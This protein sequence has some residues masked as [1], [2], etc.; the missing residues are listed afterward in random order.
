MQRFQGE[1]MFAGGAFDFD[2]KSNGA[3]TKS[4]GN[5]PD[6]GVDTA[7]SHPIDFSVHRIFCVGAAPTTICPFGCSFVILYYDDISNPYAGWNSP[8]GLDWKSPVRPQP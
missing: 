4:D 1:Q 3:T 2:L 8:P 5:V 6:C 7:A